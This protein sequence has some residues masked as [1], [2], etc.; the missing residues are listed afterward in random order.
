MT[1]AF[2]PVLELLPLLSEW[3][4]VV[5]GT[6]AAIAF[7]GVLLAALMDIGGQIQ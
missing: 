2:A 5:V 3:L 6:L 7:V 4:P 1:E